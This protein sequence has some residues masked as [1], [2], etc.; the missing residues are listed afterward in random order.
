MNAALQRCVEH[1]AAVLAAA[2][3]RAN[4]RRG[5]A[6]DPLRG[7]YV[8]EREVDEIVVSAVSSAGHVA[9]E[10]FAVPGLDRLALDNSEA[11]ILALCTAA[12]VI[13][14]FDRV[15][16]F[17]HDDLTRRTL[18][19][20]LLLELLCSTLDERAHVLEVLAP[21]AKLQRLALVHVTP[22]DAPLNSKVRID[23]GTFEWLSGRGKLDWRLNDVAVFMESNAGGER[24]AIDVDVQAGVPLTLWGA[25]EDDL[26]HASGALASARDVSVVELAP[27]ATLQQVQIGARDSTVRG[28]LLVIRT[29][30]PSQAALAARTL[31]GL[32]V[33]TVITAPNGVLGRPSGAHARISPRE[34]LTIEAHEASPLPY[35][36]R[37]VPRRGMD[38]LVLPPQRLRAVR[39]VARRVRMREVVLR[40]WKMQTGSSRGGVR[41][42]FAGPPGTGKTLAAEAV[43]GELG[44]DLYVIDLSS[45]VS[46]Y[47]GETEKALSNI[48]AQAARSGVCLLFDE[49]D[50]LF[51]K[52]T[53]V[54]DAHDRYANI[55]TA[56]LLQAI[57]DYPD[58]VLLATNI[59]SNID[60]AMLRRIDVLVEFPMPDI[61]ARRKLWEIALADA[62]LEDADSDLIAERFALSGGAIQSAALTA[63][64]EAAAEDRRIG[65]LDLLRAARDEM[66]KSGRIAGRMELGDHYD[67]L[68]AE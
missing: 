59:L 32:P 47:I 38:Y 30:A 20:G 7:M 52:R 4:S 15:V 68:M 39:S 56:Y 11:H 48:F 14:R 17:L 33:I 3:T 21:F 5:K 66:A 37:V 67:A 6:F 23:E 25:P 9:L 60:E 40:D 46:K 12:E 49:A 34:G 55:E 53:S 65:M 41:A 26:L 16:G 27:G 62:P 2:I 45:V 31:S 54:R 51:G 42:L 22:D 24:S 36:R 64:Y 19:V 43:A 8:T 63:A 61:P 18:T 58:V 13:P 44:R 10:A 57:D 29:D 35:G 1:T 50:A 28:A